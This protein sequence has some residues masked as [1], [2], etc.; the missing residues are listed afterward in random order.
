MLKA[1]KQVLILTQNAV[2][3]LRVLQNN[4]NSKLLKI[5]TKKKGCSGLS[6]SLEYVDKK[7]KFDEVVEQD[8]VTVLVDSRA[9]F[10]LIGSEMDFKKNDLSEEF[11]FNNPNI[12][13]TCG[14]GESFMV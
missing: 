3:R 2:K 8:G 6:Y 14:C 9:L 7:M 12:K 13:E 1:K 11:V 5:G 10:S 4:E